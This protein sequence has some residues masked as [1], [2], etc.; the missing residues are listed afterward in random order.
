VGKL[1]IRSADETGK[2]ALAAGMRQCG[3]V[4]ATIGPGAIGCCYGRIVREDTIIPDG[5]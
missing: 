3:L 1:A 4:A 2:P 5:G